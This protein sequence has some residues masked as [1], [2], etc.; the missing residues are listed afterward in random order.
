MFY[1][2]KVVCAACISYVVVVVIF[3]SSTMIFI[4]YKTTNF[5][6]GAH[7]GQ[8]IISL[9][10]KICN[11]FEVRVSYAVTDNASNM[12]KAFNIYLKP[13]VMDEEVDD[14]DGEDEAIDDTVDTLDID[15]EDIPVPDGCT[16]LSCFAHSLQLTVGDGLQDRQSK[17]V[18][19]YFY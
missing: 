10:D 6:L 4:F 5:D 13:T 17:R 19:K 11:Q 7:T 14:E 1:G 15:A 12:K 2:I 8:N 3:V 16:R 9:F 18:L